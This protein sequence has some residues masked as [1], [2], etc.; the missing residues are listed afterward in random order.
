MLTK[1][2]ILTRLLM[3]V[4]GLESYLGRDVPILFFLYVLRVQLS[5][6]AQVK[7]DL[8]LSVIYIF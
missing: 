3:L 4:W 1:P 6:G 2:S 7:A 5:L 8:R